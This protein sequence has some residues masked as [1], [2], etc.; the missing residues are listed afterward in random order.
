MK[1]FN[2]PL[3]RVRRWRSEQLSVEEL[4]LQQ[5]RA[6]LETL[7]A[8][9]QQINAELAEVE[10]NL[11][12]R[13]SVEALELASL[14]SYRYYVRGRVRDF[15]QRER[16]CEAKIVEQRAN[17][18]EARRRFELLDRLKRLLDG[19]PPP[20][21]RRRISSRS[22]SWPSPAGTAS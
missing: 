17:L 14:D 15:E 10:R 12:S 11:L 19:A 3:E 6:Q 8:G 22:Y 7:A 16:Q 5:L 18:L 2:F 1:R 13:K 20:I 9:K 21:K 4:K